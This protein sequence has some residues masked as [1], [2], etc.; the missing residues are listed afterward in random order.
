[1]LKVPIEECK[2]TL[3]TLDKIKGIEIKSGFSNLIR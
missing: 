1:M 3:D 2:N